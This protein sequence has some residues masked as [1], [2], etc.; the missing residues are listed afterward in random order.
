MWWLRPA[1]KVPP[2]IRSHIFGR[3]LNNC[4]VPIG[5]RL[6]VETRIGATNATWRVASKKGCY[7]SSSCVSPRTF[8]VQPR[9]WQRVADG[10]MRAKDG[11]ATF[12]RYSSHHRRVA[13]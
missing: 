1:T 8:A 12:D 9:R 2:N 7:I 6:Y 11:K 3:C 4:L 5:Q 13:L 10:W